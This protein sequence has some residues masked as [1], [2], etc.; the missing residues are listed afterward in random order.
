MGNIIS[1]NKGE[2]LDNLKTS[3]G[4]LTSFA[5][6]INDTLLELDLYSVDPKTGS[7]R[8]NFEVDYTSTGIVSRPRNSDGKLV[9][10][11][12]IP[13]NVDNDVAVNDNLGLDSAQITDK[14]W[15]DISKF[16]NFKRGICNATT[17]V[18]VNT[19]GVVLPKTTDPNYNKINS[20]LI[21]GTTNGP[22]SSEVI[23]SGTTDVPIYK[24]VT[25]VNN[26]ND[27]KYILQSQID[28][29]I[30]R[31][32]LAA[33]APGS[34]SPP[35]PN[36][37]L[38][39]DYLSRIYIPVK[40]G[41]TKECNF[42][43]SDSKPITMDARG[44]IFTAMGIENPL[45]WIDINDLSIND[46]TT[47]S[48]S[49]V[50][51][52]GSLIN[53]PTC[54]GFYAINNPTYYL[55]PDN[56]NNK[57][58]YYYDNK[59][60][61]CNKNSISIIYPK[62]STVG[63][64]LSTPDTTNY[65]ECNVI[66]IPIRINSS[67]RDSKGS[68]YTF[69]S[70]IKYLKEND[71]LQSDI[72][73]ACD[74]DPSLDD[75]DNVD[76]GGI[77]IMSTKGSIIIETR[78]Y[79]KNKPFPPT[80]QYSIFLKSYSNIQYQAK[81]GN[82]TTYNYTNP[83]SIPDIDNARD[84]LN[85][86]T[87]LA[88]Q[89]VYGNAMSN[90]CNTLLNGMITNSYVMTD[91]QEYTKLSDILDSS[92]KNSGGLLSTYDGQKLVTNKDGNML[93][94]KSDQ[95]TN[96]KN[97]GGNGSNEY[98]T[99]ST[100]GK[101][102]ASDS[103]SIYTGISK[104]CNTFYPT[105]CDYYY[106]NDFVDGVKYNPSLL[107][108]LTKT[109]P[110]GFTNNLNYLSEHIPDCR[111][112]NNFGVH[113]QADT[114]SISTSGNT[115]SIQTGGGG[116]TPIQYYYIKNK[117]NAIESK[118]TSY[119]TGFSTDRTDSGFSTY[120]RKL[121]DVFTGGG[122]K[123]GFGTQNDPAV[124]TSTSMYDNTFLYAQNARDSGNLTFNTYTCDQSETIIPT[125]TGGNITIAGINLDCIFPNT[126]GG[127]D[128]SASAGA[129]VK[130]NKP[131]LSVTINSPPINLNDY[132]E[133][134]DPF[135]QLNATIVF[136]TPSYNFYTNDT[137]N[138]GFAFQSLTTG[139]TILGS[140]TC[141]DINA[142]VNPA[143]CNATDNFT[144]LTPFLYGTTTNEYGI[145]YTLSI[146]SISNTNTIT[147]STPIPCLLKQY[148]MQI[149]DVIPGKDSN[150][151]NLYL[152]FNIK[153]NCISTPIIPYVVMLI[154][155]SSSNSMIT[156]YGTD[157]L[158]DVS[159]N[160]GSLNNII[161]NKSLADGTLTVGLTQNTTI[162]PSAYTYKILLNPNVDSAGKYSGGYIMKYSSNVPSI[163]NKINSSIDFGEFITRFN[164]INMLYIDNNNNDQITLFPSNTSI[165]NFGITIILNWSFTNVDNYTTFN[166]YY[167][168]GSDEPVL[169]PSGIS[170]NATS[171]QF[172]LPII[173]NGQKIS[174]SI[175]ATGSNLPDLISTQSLTLTSTPAPSTFNGWIILSN[176]KMVTSSPL[177][178][179]QSINDYLDPK[180]AKDGN[181]NAVM[182]DYSKNVWTSGTITDTTETGG[183]V[184]SNT[185]SVIFLLPPP[186]NMTIK[187][188]DKNN[189][190][191]ES[192]TT[193]EI[194]AF[195]NINWVLDN[196]LTNDTWAQIYIYDKIYDKFMIPKNTFSGT[197]QFTLYDLTGGISSTNTSLY[198]SVY[199]IYKSDPIQFIVSNSFMKPNMPDKTANSLSLSL[200]YPFLYIAPNG[201]NLDS[202]NNINLTLTNPLND[203]IY[204]NVFSGY[205]PLLTVNK[206]VMTLQNVNY[207][208]PIK[209]NFTKNDVLKY[210]NVLYGNIRKN[211][212]EHFGNNP[213]KR[214]KLIEGLSNKLIMNILRVD[215]SQTKNIQKS[216]LI[217]YIFNNY[218]AVSIS[219]LELYFGTN[220]IDNTTFNISFLGEASLNG[221]I[222]IGSVRVIG[223]MTDKVFFPV[224]IP[225]ATE[226]DYST[227]TTGAN[228]TWASSFTLI[229]NNNGYYSI[230]P[231]DSSAVSAA[232]SFALNPSSGTKT[233]TGAN[234]ST[235]DNSNG[236]NWL[237]Y[238]G[239]AV[240]LIILAIVIYFKFFA[241]KK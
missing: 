132:T 78:K 75:G 130:N 35:G 159:A 112:S 226:Y 20:C 13:Y 74:L 59:P 235:G 48:A 136:P 217:N 123:L 194:G 167:K 142:G 10:V 57:I 5:K 76:I 23:L 96:D 61:T 128:A 27:R 221:N 115:K 118:V 124:I 50:I 46:S 7:P 16:Y 168:I 205:N 98:Y 87:G 227:N 170:T 11:N 107:N 72:G 228:S 60:S 160:K 70:I 135:E 66:L 81:F 108:K 190:S 103:S 236:T 133:P 161:F 215:L 211:K 165:A 187:L 147:P 102:S 25:A 47:I 141:G 209:I 151:S 150:T 155:V 101:S 197:Y 189:V 198:V 162:N 93:Y 2:I 191:I 145:D 174:F 126:T 192:G 163:Y 83:N 33:V 238:G 182:Y 207:S 116:Y 113:S 54:V 37:I 63:I 36:I 158:S 137:P 181:Y 231:D 200:M 4:E 14:N 176:L 183:E 79:T 17:N 214:I 58:K 240:V 64:P 153:F 186:N 234:P 18:P 80:M 213:L 219:S 19:A 229:D 164:Y 38:V 143:K 82:T 129:G 84:I 29:I 154:P 121:Y 40:Y 223:I 210:T 104:D 166:I 230:N 225:G 52:W 42:N 109:P 94:V 49:S 111:C 222:E 237:L 65:S 172:L 44:I 149:T 175:Q 97:Y 100:A 218:D 185:S 51:K 157:L 196:K 204:F 89:T 220:N 53:D 169:L 127:T 232:N 26:I 233:S 77:N 117:C 43:T 180:T 86:P 32:S 22:T 146:K 202:I 125:N 28:N 6:N 92:I 30:D 179:Y 131:T 206:Y 193:V 152:Q 148:A 241:K 91:I 41:S 68:P 106:Y 144:I 69:D 224:T 119:G 188:T 177:S 203:N 120:L 199:N 105:Y 201:T 239:I 8:T 9:D 67:T 1:D 184:N 15:K 24:T 31:S 71:Y 62:Y 122:N 134:I 140:Y 95:G 139:N 212:K 12:G 55:N 21:N 208:N 178:I 195:V 171:Y 3:E 34:F 45:I 173:A 138:Y 88:N 56:P 216:I 110:T 73:K 99:L 114:P 90:D 156:I 39:L 85:S